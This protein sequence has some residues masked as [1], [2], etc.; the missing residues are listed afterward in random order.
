MNSA[1]NHP[2][3][4]INI[5]FSLLQ[6]LVVST[7][8]A[9]FI[10]TAFFTINLAMTL[11]ISISAG[12]LLIVI[13]RLKAVLTT[14]LKQ[15]FAPI[16]VLESWATQSDNENVI[17]LLK[18]NTPI[19]HTI[20]KLQHQL[21]AESEGNSSFDMLV[22]EKAL[23]DAETGI[24]NREFFNNRLEALLQEGDAHGAVLLFHFKEC[25]TVQSLYGKQQATSLLN[26]FIRTLQHRLVHLPNYFIA[27]HNDFELA[28]LIPNIFVKET[29]RLA[30]RL[31]NNLMSVSLPVGI[32]NDECIHLGISFFRH[33][34]KPYQVMAEADMALRSAQLQGPSQWFMYDKDE[35]EQAQGSLKWRTMLNSIISKNAFII[36]FQPVVDQATK[37][38]R[39][40]EVLAKMR[41]A[42]GQLISARIFM[43]MVRK[44][45]F[46]KEVDL[47][48]FEQVCKLLSY[49]KEQA[50][51]SLNLSIESLLSPQFIAQFYDLI[52]QY[53]SIVKKIIIEISEYHLVN[54][55][56]QLKPIIF[57]LNNQG[58]AIIA[59]KVGQ[60]VMS[61]HYLK[62]CPISALKLHRSVVLNIQHKPENQTV[63]QSLKTICTPLNINVYALGV[64]SKEEWQVL[65]ALGINGGQGHFFIKPVAQAV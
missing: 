18:L 62:E 13:S 23:L 60:Y 39:H 1:N 59:D 10:L 31:I 54:H 36:Y 29:E 17:P 22:R 28:L 44:C 32:S 35:V 12:V 14:A 56:A 52:N 9:L 6:G 51:C 11:F 20:A 64:E 40:Q 55:L 41:D 57:H 42:E 43:P 34:A 49:E 5:G 50:S 53:P 21:I 25:D 8:I 63:I 24:G 61:T 7:L 48:I 38:I 4:I 45:G 19:G 16:Q 26:T 27:R 2:Q 47:L 3:K 15:T 46:S 30:T 58:I 37:K 65:E 33:S